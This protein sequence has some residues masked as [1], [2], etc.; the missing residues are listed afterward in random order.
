MGRN[1]SSRR[2]IYP[3]S[4]FCI[5]HHHAIFRWMDRTPTS[6]ESKVFDVHCVK[7]STNLPYILTSMHGTIDVTIT[8]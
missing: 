2:Y 4:D 1:Q 3:T 8:P 6:A 7:L 5:P